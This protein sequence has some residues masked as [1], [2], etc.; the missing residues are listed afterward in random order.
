MKQVTTGIIGLDKVLDGGFI[1]PSIVLIAGTAGT[2]KTTLVMQSLFNA[3]KKDEICMYITALSEPIAMINNFMKGFSFYD[4]SQLGKGNVRYVPIDIDIIHKGPEAIITE[5][6][7]NIEIIKPD[8]IVIDPANVFTMGLNEE[9]K[10]QFYYDFFSAMKGWNSLV[11]LTG[12]FTTEELNKSTLAYLVDCVINISYEPFFERNIR[13][14]NIL[15]MRGVNF[16]SGKHSCKLSRNGFEVFPRL[17]YETGKPVLKERISTGVNG[18]DEMTGGGF[19]RGSSILISGSSG[20]GKTIMGLQFIIHGLLRNEPCLI[21]SLE[22]DEN[23]VRENAKAFNWNFGEFENK[24]LLKIMSP[25]EFDIYELA[26]KINESVE[27]IHAKR[28]LFDGTARIQRMMPQYTQL[29]EYMGGIIHYLRNKNITAIYTNEIS[30]LTGAA[31][32]D[33]TDIANNIDTIII[34]KYVEIKS[35]MRK[36]IS[37]LKMRGSDHIKEIKE[38]TIGSKGLEIKLPFSDYTGLLSGNPIKA[39]DAFMEAFKKMYK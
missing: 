32:I 8:R 14:L 25:H 12:E 10:R 1:R 6:V 30:N 24:K 13:Y 38:V 16:S 37:V 39:S 2:G 26:I 20:T 35:E 7:K 9:S 34:L 11:L 15:K 33:D 27:E 31:Q 18:L 21:V 22:E 29:P 4:I 23:Q 5:M 3:A 17:K 28:V 19:I 36:A